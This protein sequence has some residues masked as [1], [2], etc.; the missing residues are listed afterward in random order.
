MLCNGHHAKPYIPPQWPGQD[1][2]KGRI[3]HSHDYKDPNKGFIDSCTIV[4][5]NFF[6]SKLI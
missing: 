2:F 3:L 4:V 6:N 1:K 5:Y